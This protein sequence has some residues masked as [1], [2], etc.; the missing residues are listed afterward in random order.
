MPLLSFLARQMTGS[1]DEDLFPSRRLNRPLSVQL[2]DLRGTH[3]D[4]RDAPVPVV[5]IYEENFLEFSYVFCS[6]RSQQGGAHALI[7]GIIS[8][9]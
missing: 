1:G 7:R 8:R 4:G 2:R 9:R 6:G 3:S 5:R